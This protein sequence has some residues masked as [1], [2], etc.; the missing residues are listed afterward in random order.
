[1]NEPVRLSKRVAAMVPCSRSQAERYIEGGWVSVNGQVVQE[2]QCRVQ[3]ETVVLHPEASLLDLGP[4]TIV[5]HKPPGIVAEREPPRS[6][7]SAH[8]LLQ[9]AQQFQQDRSG[10][11]LLQKHLRNLA[12]VTPLAPLASGMVVLTQDE[13]IAR[14]L[15]QDAAL[16]EHEVVVDV[17]GRTEAT[18]LARLARTDH[19][20]HLHGVLLGPCKVSWQNEDRL[21]FALKGETRGQLACFCTSLGLVVQGM[22]RIRIGR[23]A[24][25]DLP[26]GQWRYLLP[27]E[28]F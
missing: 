13:R 27:H 9:A 12:L 17:T 2:P 10:W 22:K 5:L 6:G 25:R 16:V 21:R 18:D 14:K 11:H 23:V 26:V 20:V 28:K 15:L 8:T 3:H 4:V 7:A 1:M 24:M 19:G